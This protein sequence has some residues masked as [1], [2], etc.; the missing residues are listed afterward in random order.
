MSGVGEA[1][2]HVFRRPANA[3]YRSA[4]GMLP[5]GVYGS[6]FLGTVISACLADFGTPVFCC[7]QDSESLLARARSEIP[8]HEKDLQEVIRRNVRVGRLVYSSDL[9]KLVPNAQ[10]LFL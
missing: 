9:Q 4:Q 2:L 1:A 7:D 6:G 3:N 10:F 8:F 5:I